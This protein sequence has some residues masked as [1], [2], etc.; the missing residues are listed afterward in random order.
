MPQI[1]EGGFQKEILRDL[2]AYG[3]GRNPDNY[4]LPEW[5]L[6][7][8]KETADSKIEELTGYHEILDQIPAYKYSISEGRKVI[9]TARSQG[10]L[11]ANIGYSQLFFTNGFQLNEESQK[12]IGH[13]FTGPAAEET[14]DGRNYYAKFEDDSLAEMY[15]DI[16]LSSNLLPANIEGDSSGGRAHHP[17]SYY[18]TDKHGVPHGAKKVKND[19]KELANKLEYPI[20]IYGMLGL[21]SELEDFKEQSLDT[22]F[23]SLRLNNLKLN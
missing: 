20:K 4:N 10:S 13:V 5:L 17:N 11:F 7:I 14:G 9:I 23:H 3:Y 19:I 1:I 22:L 12:S 16:G 21:Y 8:A 2:Q 15:W 6:E 18:R